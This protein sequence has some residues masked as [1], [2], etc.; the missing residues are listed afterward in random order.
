MCV[1][2]NV[3]QN[4]VGFGALK[5]LVEG[6]K[7]IVRHGMRSNGKNLTAWSGVLGMRCIGR[8]HLRVKVPRP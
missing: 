3:I 4:R 6:I 1:L 7:R 8:P 5:I 2:E